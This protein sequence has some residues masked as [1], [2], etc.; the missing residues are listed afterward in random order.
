M[1]GF[2]FKEAFQSLLLAAK[3]SPNHLIR[4]TIFNFL[5]G[6]G[7]AIALYLLKVII[8]GISRSLS[9]PITN[10]WEWIIAHP[11][12]WGSIIGFVIVHLLLDSLETVASFEASSFRDNV[13]GETKI[14]IF[15]KIAEFRDI[16]LFEDTEL[17]N[18]LQLAL[19]GI[20]KLSHLSTMFNAFL[21]GFFG[22]VPIFLLAFSIAW[23]IP[24]SVFLLSI[25]SVC[26]QFRYSKKGW[27]VEE[28]QAGI[29]RRMKLAENV[30]TQDEHAKELRLFQLQSFFLDRWRS[31]FRNAYDEVYQL[32]KKGTRSILLWSMLSGLGIGVPF[33]YVV[34]AAMNGIYTLGDL[35]L[36]AG[37]VLQVSR[38]FFLLIVSTMEIY[39]TALGTSPILHLLNMKSSIQDPSEQQGSVT[40]LASGIAI[41]DLS[42]AYPHSEKPALE[43]INLTIGA[44]E[45][46]AIVGH[47]GAGKSTLAKLLCRLYDPQEGSISWDG[48]DIRSIELETLRRHIAV[49]MQDYAQFPTTA[50]ENVGFGWLPELNDDPSIWEAV[51]KS[52]LEPAFNS[53]SDS[54]ETPLT[55]QLENGTELSAGQWQRVAFARA[56]I[57]SAHA[58]LLILDE[59]TAALDPNVEDEMFG[60]FHEITRD[61]MAVI[62][63]HRL[64]LARTA[65]KIVTLNEG[66]IVEVGTHD[67]LIAQN[68]L[69]SHMFNLQ[70]SGYLGTGDGQTRL[71]ENR[72][73]TPGK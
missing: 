71:K 55:K 14:R 7:P 10:I 45:T 59:P 32:R 20:P 43:A 60:L 19:S 8:D 57:R 2:S 65:D 1:F 23:W 6:I 31:L 25:P 16:A 26:I 29:V 22:F 66:K 50:R 38:S 28:A 68:G 69:Y 27:R 17:L 11:L 70:A 67:E 9:L 46:V 62:I 37:I 52:G 13:V 47:N 15:R 34:W 42:F 72:L 48:Q 35:A 54:L 24:L 3:A 18:T 58:Q 64:S 49:L 51:R 4:L 33:I 53:L 41:Q 61:K 36:Y 5:S 56:I 63:S 44:G 12:F 30:L 40:K 39:E 73:P 21:M